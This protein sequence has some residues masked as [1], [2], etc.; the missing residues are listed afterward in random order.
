MFKL[1]ER[2]R[3]KE[4]SLYQHVASIVLTAGAVVLFWR[5]AWGL[6]DHFLFPETPILSYFVS[7]FLGLLILYLDDKKISELDHH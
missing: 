2:F 7:I 3:K 4:P 1:F 6:M 5:G